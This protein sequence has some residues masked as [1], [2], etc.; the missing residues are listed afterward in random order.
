MDNRRTFLKQTLATAALAALSQ[1]LLAE[2]PRLAGRPPEEVAADETFWAQVREAYTPEPGTVWF[3]NLAFNP[4]PRTVHEAFL[5]NERAFNAWPLAR[6]ARVFPAEARTALRERLA[7]MLKASPDE[8]ALTRNTTEGLVT[9]IFGLDLKPGD[10]V[11]ITTHDYGTFL[12]AWHQRER[13]DGITVK[14]IAVPTPP[15][16]AD[17][18]VA[19]FA[20]A[21][22]DKTRVVMLCHIVDPSGLM[23]PVRR[24]AD[25]A[26]GRGAQV[27]VDGALSF[28][29]LP[30]DVKAL[31]CDYFAT[32]LHKGV[33]APWGTGLLYVKKERIPALWPLFGAPADR[34]ADI[35]KL[36]LIGTAPVTQ[37]ATMNAALDV[38]DAIGID[39]IAA[40]YR[41]LF[42]HWTEQVAGV[43]R[44]KLYTP[45][46][47]DLS[48]GIGTVGVEGVAPR[49]LYSY[50]K[51]KRG[52]STWPIDYD[53][54][55]GVWVSPYLYS[56]PAE[57]DR[58]VAVLKAV[59]AQGLPA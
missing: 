2:Q 11:V 19:A 5:A 15:A 36:E 12:T 47:T 20:Q 35:R 57:L 17:E 32:S 37:W 28:G 8:V 53:G 27:I 42:N 16:S 23:M 30:V 31:G 18:V 43:P 4:V 34:G 9:V 49:P 39:R 7:R 3:N 50:L 14:R 22:G 44:L 52:I 38:H 59:A 1:R 41:H 10:E 21:I 25:L 13:R 33:G 26:H 58:L 40:R 48:L 24:V 6:R 55:Q 56:T 51:D 46:S 54:F 45:R 29:C